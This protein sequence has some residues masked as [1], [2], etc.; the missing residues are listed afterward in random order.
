MI[1]KI[2]GVLALL[3]IGG[4]YILPRLIEHQV[5]LLFG[6]NSNHQK[7]KDEKDFDEANSIWKDR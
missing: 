4:A 7:S 5:F 2:V 3:V 1:L 6:H